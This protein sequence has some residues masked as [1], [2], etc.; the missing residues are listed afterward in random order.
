MLKSIVDPDVFER[1]NF[2]EI[3]KIIGDG[4]EEIITVGKDRTDMKGTRW[5][6]RNHHFHHHL[7][8]HKHIY[9]HYPAQ[10]IKKGDDKVARETH[11]YTKTY[12]QTIIDLK[13][14]RQLISQKNR[15]QYADNAFVQTAAL[16]EDTINDAASDLDSLVGDITHDINSAFDD[17]DSSHRHGVMPLSGSH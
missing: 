4:D 15:Q 10:N 9:H 14:N 7:T 5:L 16:I 13:R 3:N 2:K 11:S 17:D 1:S 6:A 8:I 12:T